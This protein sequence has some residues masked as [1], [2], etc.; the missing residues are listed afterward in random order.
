[1]AAG[2]GRI[3]HALLLLRNFTLRVYCCCAGLQ[4]DNVTMVHHPS[5]FSVKLCVTPLSRDHGCSVTRAVAT[6]R[7]RRRRPRP[8][9]GVARVET[10]A[11]APCSPAPAHRT[12]R[13]AELETLVRQVFTSTEKTP[14]LALSLLNVPTSAFTFK[15]FLRHYA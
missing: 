8:A 13:D 5:H 9:L 6:A 10:P 15:N 2:G 4:L 11:A 3:S 14:I 7:L 1:M 12:H